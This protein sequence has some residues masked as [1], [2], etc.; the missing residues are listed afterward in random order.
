MYLVWS[1]AHEELDLSADYCGSE[2]FFVFGF[3]FCFSPG[4]IT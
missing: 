2:A 4:K 1:A 3:C